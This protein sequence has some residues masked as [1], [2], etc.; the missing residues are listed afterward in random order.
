MKHL[1]N[2]ISKEEKQSILEQHKGGIKIINEKFNQLVNKKLEDY[3]KNSG[4]KLPAIKSEEDL[5]TFLD[6][7]GRVDLLTKTLTG[8]EGNDEG[9]KYGAKMKNVLQ[10]LLKN[11]AMSCDNDKK[12]YDTV[13]YSN[14]VDNFFKR[15]QMK[16]DNI[17][18]SRELV[19][20]PA[21]PGY[22]KAFKDDFA[23]IVQAQINK[24]S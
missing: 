18:N 5:Q 10:Q 4:I 2:N 24:L 11:V 16:N 14:L 17:E 3:R 21:G 7:Q 20:K 15:M 8:L 13:K 22:L 23:N 9:S 12:C 19:I 1:L 6:Y